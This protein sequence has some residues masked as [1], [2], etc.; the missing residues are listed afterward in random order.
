MV[1]SKFVGAT[2]FYADYNYG[3]DDIESTNDH[4]Y[5]EENIETQAP[6]EAEIREGMYIKIGFIFLI[7]GVTVLAGMTP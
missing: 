7:F 6:D 5:E 2:S 1:L 3:H 4:L